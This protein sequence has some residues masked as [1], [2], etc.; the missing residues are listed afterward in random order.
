MNKVEAFRHHLIRL[1]ELGYR[2]QGEAA[3]II[4]DVVLSNIIGPAGVGKSSINHKITEIDPDFSVPLGFTSRHPRR[5]ENLKRYRHI[6]D[7]PDS[8]QELVSKADAGQL[9]Q[10]TFH[11]TTGDI[12]GTEPKDYQTKYAVLDMMFQYVEKSHHIGFKAVKDI[13]IVTTA[14]GYDKQLGRQSRLIGDPVQMEKRRREGILCLSWC[15]ERGDEITWVHNRYGKLDET[16]LEVI[17]LIKGQLKP[18]PG[19][20]RLGEQLL[21]KLEG[22]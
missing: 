13:A 1:D 6:T 4:G 5:N 21:K 10:Y 14:E 7:T 9:V 20:R 16:A 8:W 15:L 18:S 3:K 19:N 11:T 22:F 2:P 17:G 12:Y